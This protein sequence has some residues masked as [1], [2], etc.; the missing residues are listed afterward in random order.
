[1][2]D[3]F[4]EVAGFDA[5]TGAFQGAEALAAYKR[6]GVVCLRRAFGRDWLEVIDAGIEQAVGGGALDDAVVRRPGDRGAFFAGSRMWPKVAPFRRFIF[7]S[8][9]ADLFWPLLES[10]R[11]TLFYDF[12]LIKD[13]GSDSAATPW[14]QD[15]S[16]YPLHGS[17]V[18]NCWIALDAIPL[19]TAL[20]FVRGSHRAGKLY[21]AISFDPDLI[22]PHSQMERPH[23]PEAE[24][25]PGAEI[26]CT[27]L[28]PGD[29]LVWN[30]HTLHAAPGNKLDRRRAAYSLNWAGDDV[31]F[32][33]IP[34]L[35]TYRSPGQVHGQSLPA[36]TFPV[37]REREG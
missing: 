23:P 28:Q 33:D 20:R 34:S 26:L 29:T 15:H 36:E 27:A 30:S 22:Y 5:A 6:D 32:N 37:L 4:C 9:A 21:R 8:H 31:T 13:A 3:T 25:D 18:I 14:H 1:M 24:G 16:F 17:K 7:D 11:L 35:E 12:L 2:K 19:E 10:R